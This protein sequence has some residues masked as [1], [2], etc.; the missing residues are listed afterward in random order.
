MTAQDALPPDSG[1]KDARD[2]LLQNLDTRVSKLEG[3]TGG[4]FKRI[5]QNASASALFLGL[6]LSAASLY[7][8]FVAKPETA[9]VTRIGQFNQ[10]VNSALKTRQ[11]ALQVQIQ[12]T[13]PTLRMST[14][15]MSMPQILND[16]ATAR[17]IMEAMEDRDIGIP[18]LLVLI[19]EAL[20]VNDLRSAREFAD[21]AVRKTDLPPFLQ[22]EAYRQ[23]ARVFFAEGRF[24]EA[25]T[26][27]EQAVGKFQPTPMTA[28]ARAFLFGDWITL[29]LMFSHCDSAQGVMERFILTLPDMP[30]RERNDMAGNLAGQVEQMRGRCPNL[31]ELPIGQFVGMPG[32]GLP[33]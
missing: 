25:R 20:N 8:V 13:D 18:Q 27:F 14:M 4:L 16:V 23:Q 30:P 12:S 31:P 2:I 33:R 28:G 5:T 7:D 17:A 3:G 29:E 9:R 32:T 22:S 1:Q 24:A 15:S 11:Q 10:A 26:S 21:R 19:N 6:I